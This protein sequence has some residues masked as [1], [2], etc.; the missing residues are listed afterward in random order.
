MTTHCLFTLC[1]GLSGLLCAQ[2][3]PEFPVQPSLPE[4]PAPVFDERPK[5]NIP[6][7]EE[8]KKRSLAW[9]E[10]CYPG[11]AQRKAK[12]EEIW[13]EQSPIPILLEKTLAAFN[14][15]AAAVLKACEAADAEAAHKAASQVLAAEGD[16]FLKANLG[17]I[18]ACFLAGQKMY[19]E[20]LEV[21]SHIAV[22]DVVDPCGFLFFRGVCEFELLKKTEA[23]DTLGRL[24]DNAGS[25]PERYAALSRLMLFDMEYLDEE[26][27]DHLSRTMGDVQRRLE[28]NRVGQKVQE[29]EKEIVDRLDKL[30]KKLEEMQ[31]SGGGGGGGQQGQGGPRSSSPASDSRV[32]RGKGPG[33]IDKRAQKGA[34]AWG[35]LPEKE[36]AR[37]LQALGR[38]FP[39][40]YRSAIEEYFRKL[41]SE[42]KDSKEP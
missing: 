1:L 26:G 18:Y 10:S 42:E 7:P 25:P 23:L 31:N 37:M 19:D 15:G 17:E 12:C 35:N 4:A 40:H 20:A 38:D 33:E 27:L 11:D 41:A 28:L 6:T 39:A 9:V 21:Y 36:R 24:Q 8:A 22:E 14:D 2:E 16:T 32:M 13:K 29:E 30:I 5:L 3:Q 34:S